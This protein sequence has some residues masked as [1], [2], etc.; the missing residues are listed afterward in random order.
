MLLKTK[1]RVKYKERFMSQRKSD[2][3][4]VWMGICLTILGVAGAD[5]L[6]ASPA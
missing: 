2:I 6:A 5:L 3:L 4:T 1:N